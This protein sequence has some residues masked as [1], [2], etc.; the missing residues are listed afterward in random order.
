MVA[1]AE[2]SAGIRHL[3]QG[4]VGGKGIIQ[5]QIESVSFQFLRAAYQQILSQVLI[6]E[7]PIQH[8]LHR[9][10]NRVGAYLI[11]RV[12]GRRLLFGHF[13][14]YLGVAVRQVAVF[15]RLEG[16]APR[17]ADLL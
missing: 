7:R 9:P 6:Q 15:C 1:W 3:A 17:L 4:F 16:S 10:V 2:A 11:N 8:R 14:R 13:G 12:E 5:T